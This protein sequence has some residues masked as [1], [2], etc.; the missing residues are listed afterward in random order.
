MGTPDAPIWP[1]APPNFTDHTYTSST[2]TRLSVRVWPASPPPS[3]GCPAPFIV[4]VHGGGYIG[5]SHYIPFPWLTAGFQRRG[6]HLVMINYRLAPQASLDAQLTN[7]DKVDVDRYVVGGESAGGT[8]ATLLGLCLAPPPKAVIDVYGVVDFLGLEQ[9]A[10]NGPVA[11]EE[12]EAWTGEFSEDQL[13][14]YVA[15]RD[16]ANVLTDA[17]SWNEMEV[18]S[19]VELS[20]RWVADF[21][22]T[23][24]VRLQAELHIWRSLRKE[25]DALLKCTMHSERFEGGVS[26]YRV[27]LERAEKGKGKVEYPPT[28]FLHG[29][30]DVDV[31]IS[32]SKEM[33]RVLR[34]G[35]VEVVECYEEGVGHVFDAKY[36]GPDVAGWDTYIQP[37]LD[38]VNKYVGHEVKGVGA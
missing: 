6:Y 9:L 23:E 31:P 4:W 32:Q 1:H 27:L 5:G 34:E 13:R 22:Y 20:T 17:L 12:V 15:D 2:S 14:A 25:P 24:R 21:R 11:Q 18:I 26:A 19:D 8:F 16:P 3:L 35:G 28:A 38:F 7:C 30:A 37:I 29:T 33:A 10:V 36:T